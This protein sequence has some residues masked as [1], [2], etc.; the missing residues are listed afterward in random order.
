MAKKQPHKLTDQLRQAIEDCG[1]SRYA[2][3]QETGTDQAALSRFMR[4]Q[5]GLSLAA[6]DRLGECLQLT[7]NL[8]RK[9]G[10]KGK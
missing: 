6:L 9:P 8:G 7:V 1:V 2:I 3:S 4:G 10:T 5:V